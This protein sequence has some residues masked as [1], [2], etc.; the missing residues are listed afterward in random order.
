VLHGQGATHHRNGNIL[1][2]GYS[3][4]RSLDFLRT[5]RAIHA[6]DMEAAIACGFGHERLLDRASV[7]A[8]FL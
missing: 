3:P 5:A 4:H 7:Q 2:T 1:Y 6:D 8:Y